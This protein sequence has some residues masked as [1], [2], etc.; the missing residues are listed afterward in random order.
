MTWRV[1]H[2]PL[3][4]RR[5]PAATEDNPPP[6]RRDNLH[7]TAQATGIAIMPRRFGDPALGRML[8]SYLP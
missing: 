5:T 1:R 8:R 2:R 6:P 4:R 3:S 7:A